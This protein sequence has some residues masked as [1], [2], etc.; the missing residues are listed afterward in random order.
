MKKSTLFN[1]A[2]FAFSLFS[3]TTITGFSQSQGPN[4]AD[5]LFNNPLR[6]TAAWVN[7][8]NA[9]D[10]NVIYAYDSVTSLKSRA[11]F[12][13]ATGFN[14]TIPV[15]ATIKGI[16]AQVRGHQRN[17]SLI[18]ALN[19]ISLVK[20]SVI[21]HDS[22]TGTGLSGGGDTWQTIG[23]CSNIWNDTTWSAKD[24][25]SS[26][27]GVAYFATATF[28][29]LTGHYAMY[30]DA[31]RVTV[32]YTAP[33]STEVLSQASTIGEVY[34][35]PTKGML[36]FKYTGKYLVQLY[37]LTGKE[38]YSANL[39]GPEQVDISSLCGGMYLMHITAGNNTSIQKV[40]LQK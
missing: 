40:V 6:G 31:L 8:L 20:N 37:D 35:N 5:T 15:G 11:Q 16:T 22:L 10:S 13:E 25:D 12:L 1:K 21:Q 3:L 33:S 14:F 9:K 30:I 26:K 38:V 32:C 18:N 36:K 19:Y 23:G 34:P 27:F 39:Q 24:I 17:Q 28:L 29:T 7:P 4:Y 2:V